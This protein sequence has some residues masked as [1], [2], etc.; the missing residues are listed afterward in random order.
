M[1]QNLL[2]VTGEMIFLL[3]LI[4]IVSS[5]SSQPPHSHNIPKITRI[6]PN[7]TAT[8]GSR[9]V[10]FSCS[11]ADPLSDGDTMVWKR[12]HFGIDNFTTESI[13]NE[14]QFGRFNVSFDSANLTSHLKIYE[15]Q[16]RDTGIY[17]CEIHPHNV[18]LSTQLDVFGRPY[19]YDS[20]VNRVN[21]SFAAEPTPTVLRVDSNT[22]LLL[23]CAAGGIPQPTVH[24]RHYTH[25]WLA[26]NTINS[27]ILSLEK[28]TKQDTGT[29]TCFAE[30]SFG[31][32]SRVFN[33][34]FSKYPPVIHGCDLNFIVKFKLDLVCLIESYVEP[35][36]LWV[37]DGVQLES[38]GD[39][40][41]IQTSIRRIRL[42]SYEV[43]LRM[44]ET[45]T[46]QHGMY[47]IKARNKFGEDE[48]T[49]GYWPEIPKSESSCVIWISLF[50]G[51]V[52]LLLIG[53]VCLLV[54]G[55]YRY[56]ISIDIDM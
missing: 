22:S 26:D 14:N 3:N 25:K 43:Y 56:I 49:I 54:V 53:I 2:I 12:T 21:D 35:K 33:I 50:S 13:P 6:T 45:F 48:M 44:N 38:E 7:Q 41:P 19:F 37:K 32:I 18:S 16:V 20:T 29:Y 27:S 30:N 36:I 42:D 46:L 52:S 4:C 39:I 17:T 1:R 51:V 9:S 15:V 40:N 23:D 47:T 55:Y 11:T 8:S 34:N 5:V 10:E 24:I 31:R 28:I